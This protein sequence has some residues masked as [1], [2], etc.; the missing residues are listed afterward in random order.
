MLE[1]HGRVRSALFGSARRATCPRVRTADYSG[2]NSFQIENN[3]NNLLYPVQ[4]EKE[5]YVR[6]TGGMKLPL[7]ERR[8]DGDGRA[9]GKRRSRGR[10]RP[11]SRRQRVAAT[12]IQKQA[13]AAGGDTSGRGFSSD[14]TQP[15]VTK[16]E[17]EPRPPVERGADLPRCLLS[18]SA[19]GGPRT[20][21]C[22]PKYKE[23]PDV[24]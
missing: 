17:P 4:A 22:R 1:R 7:V 10:H 8:Y 9:E 23:N 24:I 2:T 21:T 14:R 15:G 12:G 13:G 18:K 19:R 11:Q 3:D 5:G 20:T 16:K 6:V